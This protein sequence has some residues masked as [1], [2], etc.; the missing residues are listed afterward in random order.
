MK[1]KN[2]SSKKS[3]RT[4]LSATRNIAR[5]THQICPYTDSRKVDPAT[6]S[7]ARENLLTVP[8]CAFVISVSYED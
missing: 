6:D 1:R 2:K 8:G 3:L 7:V 4:T 5:R